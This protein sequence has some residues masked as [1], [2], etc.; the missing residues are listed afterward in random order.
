[1]AKIFAG[2]QTFPDLARHLRVAIARFP[3]DP[4][5]RNLAES[6]IRL[7]PKGVKNGD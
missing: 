6:L 1:M 2:P 5:P 7:Y 3:F 4:Q